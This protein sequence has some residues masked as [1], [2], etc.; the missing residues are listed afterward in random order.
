ML[1]LV[2]VRMSESSRQLVK[3]T[4]GVGKVG[5]GHGKGEAESRV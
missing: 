4:R 2:I 5:K 3:H 1:L